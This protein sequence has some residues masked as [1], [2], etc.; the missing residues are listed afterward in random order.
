MLSACLS[1]QA[2]PI[3]KA[4]ARLVAERLVGIDDASADSVPLSPFYIFSRGAG[5]GFV[6]ASGDDS[7]APILGYT[8]QG[9]YDPASL[10]PQL[11]AMLTLW[12]ERIAEVQRR[13]Q[14]TRLRVSAPMRAVAE[15]KKEWVNVAPLLKTHWHQDYPYNMLAPEKKGVGRCMTGCVATAGSQVTYYFHKDNPSELAYNTPTY[16]YGTPVTVSLPKG[17]PI[18]WSQMKLSGKGTARQD[19]AVAKLMYALGTSAWLTYGDGDGLATSGHNNKMADAMKGQFKLNYSYKSKSE[20]SQQK[21]EELIYQNLISKRPMLYS[22]VH[23]DNGGHSV[24]L[25]GYQAAT[26][27]YHFNFG[28]GG[29]GDGYYTVDDKTGMNGF[30]TYQDLVFN[31]T[32]QRQNLKAEIMTPQLYHKVET[33]LE[34][35]IANDGT[36][37]YQGIYVYLGK[38]ENKVTTAAVAHDLSTI[39]AAGEKATLNFTVKPA[40][41]TASFLQVCD[42]NR[43]I[44][45]SLPIEIAASVADLRL[46]T[47]KVDAGSRVETVDGMDFLAVNSNSPVVTVTLT[48]GQEGT[49]CQPTLQCHLEGYNAE[50]KTWYSVKDATSATTLF[51]RGETQQVDFVFDG[52]KGDN[53]YRAWLDSKA[54]ASRLSEI[55]TDGH[56]PYVY[57]TVCDSDL[58]IAVDGRHATVTGHWNPTIFAAKATDAAVCSYDISALSEIDVKPAAANPNALF[59]TTAEN[60]ALAGIENVVAGDVCQKLAIQTNADFK[61][62][63]PF[64]ARQASLTLTEAEPGAWHGALLPFAAEMPYGMQV[65]RAKEFVAT[66]LA[67]VNHEATRSVEAMTVVTYLTSRKGLDTV[68][69]SDVDIATDTVASLFDGRLQAGTLATELQ[70]KSLVL[71]EYIGSLYFIAPAEGQTVAAAFQPVIVGTSAQRVRTTSET[72]VDGYY[73]SL[74]S[75][76]DE[77][78]DTLAAYTAARKVAAA[79]AK[80]LQDA[81]TEAQDMLTYRSHE[82]SDDVKNQRDALREAVKAFLETARQGAGKTGDVNGDGAVDVADIATVISVMASAADSVSTA[83]ADVNGDGSV[84]VADIAS[85]ISVMAGSNQR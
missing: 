33:N 81:I 2:N 76:I 32:P 64:K 78:C 27:L 5:R 1:V 50:T 79:A 43:N 84:D 26:G 9:D 25:D 57:F 21:W 41:T 65:K 54:Y 7:T 17:T 60:A 42:K 20:Y 77:A 3:T 62:W 16:G 14:V 66:G 74:S 38:I 30:N 29:Q 69:A 71:G 19:S 49:S 12:S 53:C 67:T 22:G 56:S 83:A 72:L 8:E 37:D 82:E 36:L 48:N 47:V 58:D 45:V 10:P 63:R 59:Y 34:V 6:I 46:D 15:Y 44:I 55:K 31:I 52:L 61:P 28:W 39:I 24:C 18:E 51:G 23:P 85:V 13:P 40:T 68:S 35:D 11:Q 75:A 70:P 80:T 73:R 4:E